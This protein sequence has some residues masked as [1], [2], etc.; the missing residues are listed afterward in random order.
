MGQSATAVASVDKQI[1]RLVDTVD[2]LRSLT[3]RVSALSASHSPAIYADVEGRQLGRDGTSC[4]LT[5][6]LRPDNVVYLVDLTTLG[7]ACF[8]TTSDQS[9]M[10]LRSILESEVIPKVVFDVRSQSDALYARHGIHLKA[11]HE[12][13]LMEVACRLASRKHLGSL[14]RC[15]ET[16]SAL[17]P[18]QKAEWANV[19]ACSRQLCN[20]TYGGD[21]ALLEERPLTAEIVE[22]C[23][24][25]AVCLAA[26]WDDY[27]SQLTADTLRTVSAATQLR[28]K[29]THAERYQGQG[30]HMALAPFL[31]GGGRQIGRR[32]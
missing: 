12:V 24:Q 6:Y 10:T 22:S 26:L 18:D 17:T 28:I 23:A 7:D 19:K 4:I 13:Q 16:S 27:R 32:W 21:D 11:I 29:T 8:T 25:N 1:V 31:G 30:K 20:P 14:A 5:L 2:G 15:V 9:L 3:T